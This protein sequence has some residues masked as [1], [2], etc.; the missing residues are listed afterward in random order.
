[1][2]N[3]ELKRSHQNRSESGRCEFKPGQTFTRAH[4]R[5]HPAR[6]QRAQLAI[7]LDARVEA[8]SHG[9]RHALAA[10]RKFF[11]V[12]A[13]CVIQ[14]VERS[15]AEFRS[16]AM[17][18]IKKLV[19]ALGSIEQDSKGAPSAAIEATQAALEL[20]QR[21][22]TADDTARCREALLEGVQQAITALSMFLED[23]KQWPSTQTELRSRGRARSAALR[24]TLKIMGALD[25][26][27]T[28]STRGTPI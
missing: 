3:W 12:P 4:T 25:A 8:L 9:A 18:K 7:D 2:G 26:L 10:L 1:M 19:G 14:N 20:K 5:S 11:E 27:E 13:S 17:S 16:E 15:A 24:I 6:E 28:D 23:P 22:D 21:A